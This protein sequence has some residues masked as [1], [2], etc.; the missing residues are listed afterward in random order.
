MAKPEYLF[1]DLFSGG[2]NQQNGQGHF[3]YFK[4]LSRVELNSNILDNIAITA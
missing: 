2:L 3:D 1:T 4:P